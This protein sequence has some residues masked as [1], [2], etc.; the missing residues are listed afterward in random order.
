MAKIFNSSTLLFQHFQRNASISLGW[1]V[2]I[3]LRQ[4]RD[5][6]GDLEWPCGQPGGM[7][8]GCHWNGT[9]VDKNTFANEAWFSL[10]DDEEEEHDDDDD[11]DDE[12]LSYC[13]CHYGP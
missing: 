8:L 12:L 1:E 6:V 5:I 10:H 7:T 9:L 4:L 3:S 11:D 13:D 2:D